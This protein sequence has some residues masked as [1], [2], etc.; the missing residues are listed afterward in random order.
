[1]RSKTSSPHDY[2]PYA[3]G[4]RTPRALPAAELARPLVTVNAAPNEGQLVDFGHYPRC[5]EVV[6]TRAEDAFFGRLQFV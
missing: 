3:V 6:A 5:S 2:Q 1:M 4:I